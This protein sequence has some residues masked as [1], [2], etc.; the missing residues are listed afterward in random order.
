MFWWLLLTCL[1]QQA[2]RVCA[3]NGMDVAG[4]E[5]KS[6][7]FQLQDLMEGVLTWSFCGETILVIE[8]GAPPRLVFSDKSYTSRVAFSNNGSDLTILQLRRSDAGTYLAKNNEFKVV[9]T[10]RVYRELPEPTVS[11]TGWNCSAE[12]C[13]Y[14]LH[15][16]VDP[17]E[18]SSFLW[19]YNEQPESEGSELVVVEEKLH[20]GDPD[21]L[22]YTCTVQNPVSSRSTTV[23][24]SALCAGTFS[25]SPTI[26]IAGLA[27]GLLLLLTIIIIV[28]K[29]KGRRSHVLLSSAAPRAGAATEYMTVY[30]EVGA[31]Q[32]MQPWNFPRAQKGDPKKSTASGVK[33][34]TTIYATIQA[35]AMSTGDE[36]MSSGAPGCWEQEKSPHATVSELYPMA[37]PWSAHVPAV[38]M[39]LLPATGEPSPSQTQGDKHHGDAVLM[40]DQ[41]SAHVLPPRRTL[42]PTC[43]FPCSLSCLHGY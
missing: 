1:L 8:L 18:N 14:A 37:Q 19:S 21:L 9:F 25:S 42:L 7:T 40:W 30:A 16:S 10:L 26:I 3:S 43:C 20:P 34:S 35:V 33:T 17:P 12:G 39:V 4:A 13:H 28:V 29:L 24:P 32:Q 36:K 41:S 38:S 2:S 27:I 31:V 6:V 15:C 22:P 11:C 5:G 23:F